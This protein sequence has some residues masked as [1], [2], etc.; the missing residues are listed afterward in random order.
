M[1]QSEWGTLVPPRDAAALAEAIGGLLDLPA[2]ER[3]AMGRRG[4]EFV[5][6]RFSVRDQALK[7]IGLI[8]R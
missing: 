2:G 6:S 8:D 7:L 5:A 1:V 4:R 3:A